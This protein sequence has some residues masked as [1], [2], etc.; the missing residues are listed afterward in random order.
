[1]TS[2]LLVYALTPTKSTHET[3]LEALTLLIHFFG[4]LEQQKNFV[5]LCFWLEQYK[6]YNKYHRTAEQIFPVSECGYL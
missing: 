2:V 6:L 4:G 3:S 1:M 5:H